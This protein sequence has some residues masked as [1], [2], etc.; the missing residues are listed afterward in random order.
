MGALGLLL[1]VGCAAAG[2]W[3]YSTRGSGAS[4]V[5][6]LQP[7]LAERSIEGDT[8]EHA[9]LVE[10]RGAAREAPRRESLP[11]APTTTAPVA[12]KVEATWPLRV[13][14]AA[15]AASDARALHLEYGLN[16]N[17]RYAVHWLGT[18][19]LERDGAL[20]V[21]QLPQS[22]ERRVLAVEVRSQSRDLSSGIVRLGRRQAGVE[23][24]D[25]TLREV[26][27]LIVVV[28]S[29]DSTPSEVARSE[30]RTPPGSGS[31]ATAPPR[32]EIPRIEILT[33]ARG[34]E[35]TA[36][37]ERV[38]AVDRRGP[39]PDGVPTDGGHLYE[40]LLAG[41]VDVRVTGLRWHP[42]TVAC[43]LSR[44]ERRVLTVPLQPMQIVGALSG[45][46]VVEG[47]RIPNAPIVIASSLEDPTQRFQAF[48]TPM[49]GAPPGE[50]FDWRIED[51]PAG[52]YQVVTMPLSFVPV[53][54]PSYT[55]H[56]PAEGLDFVVENDPEIRW[57]DWH[58]IDARSG[59][60]LENVWVDLERRDGTLRKVR[61]D[62]SPAERFPRNSDVRWTV[63]CEGYEP[64]SGT[65]TECD[66]VEPR[67]QR[68]DDREL[69]D[70]RMH[71][72]WVCD[73][74]LTPADR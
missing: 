28:S 69:T 23:V 40:R 10:V 71:E 7:A 9:A 60:S 21:A 15:A 4:S 24:L 46:I 33:G 2:L 63:R 27:E 44:G 55:T 3:W 52:V 6:R 16:E 25:V 12:P 5:G 62:L 42:A 66:R 37:G 29:R 13:R 64:I 53:D 30:Q 54:P 47:A 72:V 8:D 41:S 65:L 22:L 57:C 61:L 50:R 35:V 48:A 73:L 38:C 20:H 17:V 31:A 32:L 70:P 74:E 14:V 56:A 26:G 59:A 19:P 18:V 68:K 36:Y 49:V 43:R 11:A 34:G 51:L 67:A 45:T 1:G 39:R 58:V